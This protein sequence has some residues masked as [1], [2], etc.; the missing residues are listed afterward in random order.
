MGVLMCVTPLAA[1]SSLAFLNQNQPLL[2]AHNCYP[3]GGMHADRLDRAL[4]TGY[5]VSIEQDLAWYQD[6]ATGDGWPVVT[7]SS[8]P[9][10]VEPS[11]R[12]HFFEHVRPI[13][14]Q[15]LAENQRESWPLIVV[16]FDFKDNRPALHEAV[17]SLLGEYQEW[18]TT[19]VKTGNPH[20]LSPFD[21][22][23]LFVLSDSHAQEDRFFNQVPVGEKLRIFGATP[24]NPLP[25]SATPEER[26][27]LQVSAPPDHLLTEPPTNYRRWWNNPW[28]IVEQGGQEAAGDW[29]TD[30]EDRLRSLVDHAHAMGYWIRFYTLDGEDGRAAGGYHFG[31]SDAV[32]LRWKAAYQAGVDFI[33]TDQ[34]EELGDY[35]R[36]I[37]SN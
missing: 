1:Q 27:A 18:I 20:E 22:K 29:T 11:L 8:A 21:A 17:W 28:S 35:M 32:R 6:P 16:H 24:S 5:P 10:G 31:S 3:D 30:D 7:H 34:Y 36:Q 13:V 9:D 14:E 25:A 15:A 37:G 4:S 2:D 19:A 23:P 33:A 12:G 26:T